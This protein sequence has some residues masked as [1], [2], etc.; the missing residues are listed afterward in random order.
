MGMLAY[1]VIWEAK[2]RLKEILERD[3]DNKECEGNSLREVRDSLSKI[4]IGRIKIGGIEVE[5]IGI[6]QKHQ[7][8]ILNLLGTP[9]NKK[10]QQSLSLKIRPYS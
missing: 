3:P 2:Q 10:A 7:R 6:I 4:S 5:Q 1:L 9:L 8:K